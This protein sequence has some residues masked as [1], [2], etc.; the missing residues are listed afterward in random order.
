M[1]RR[2]SVTVEH[3]PL[4]QPFRIAR[5][6]KTEAAVVSC[7]IADE[8]G[9]GRAE[10]V[11]YPRYGE[12]IESVCDQIEGVR[13]LIERG[14]SRDSLA[15]AVAAG[16]ARNALDCALWDLEAKSTGGHVSAIVCGET[17]RPV[18]TAYTISLDSA[19]A[20][21]S[22]ARASGR[23][24]LKIKLGTEDDRER[25]RAVRAA[26]RGARLILDA[27]E[28][29]TDAN[30]RDHLLAAAAAGAVLVE[31]PLPAGK[32]AILAEIPHPVPVCADESLHVGKDLDHLLG[33]YDFVNVKLDKTGGLTEAVRLTR[34]ARRHG[35]GVMV[36]CMVGTSLAMAP[37]ILLAQTADI[38]DLDGPLLLAKD[39]P[40]PLTYAGSMVSPP[41]PR[42]W[43]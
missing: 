11:P 16:A 24:L 36:G 15:E 4:L 18:E 37:A 39:R 25:I 19:D 38:V 1:P 29:W 2:L 7:E 30:L 27:N 13:D 31:Q 40:H 43:G 41:D 5:G 21:A 6:V 9:R 22:A 42:L 28:G 33:R 10:C 34:E 26:A 17:P 32:D 3:F 35:F 20:M 23:D 12:S 8:Y 14:G